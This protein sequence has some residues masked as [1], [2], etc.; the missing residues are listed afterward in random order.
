MGISQSLENRDFMIN[1]DE[2]TCLYSKMAFKPK[3]EVG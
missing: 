2:P 1:R 3:M